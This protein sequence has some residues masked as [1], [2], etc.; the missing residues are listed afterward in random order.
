M[1]VAAVEHNTGMALPQV[2][3]DRNRTHGI[4]PSVGDVHPRARHVNR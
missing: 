4:C 1:M 2:E 3:V